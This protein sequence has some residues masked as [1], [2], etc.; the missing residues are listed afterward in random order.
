MSAPPAVRRAWPPWWRWSLRGIAAAAALL[1]VVYVGYVLLGTN[2]HTVIPGAV[3]RTAQPS[4]KRLEAL[5]RTYGI[6]TIVNLR[7][8]CDP[9]PW[10]L[11]ECIAA[12]RLNLSQEDIPF[13]ATRLPPVD[14]VLDRSEKPL[15]LHCNRGA[16]RSGMAATMAVLLQTDTPLHDARHQL[17]PRYGHI[18]LARTSNMDR[19]FDL[20]EEWLAH[21]HLT[22]SSEVFRRWATKEYCPGECR[23]Q[24]EV[25]DHP[26]TPLRLYPAQVF[27]FHIRSR[28][29]SVKPW[30]LR[31]GSNA[32]IHV[33]YTVHDTDGGIVRDGRGALL[34]ATVAPGEEL[35]V[36]LS[37]VAPLTPGRYELRVD[38]VDEQHAYFMQVGSEPL[39]WKLEVV[40]P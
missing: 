12:N 39:C 10:Y 19:F 23:C 11:D 29:T 31:P 36:V 33:A 35:D 16:D 2:F 38:M 15:L 25:L 26:P 4:A 27:P 14:T 6:R 17:G 18:P 13:S 24:F 20:Y 5:V 1:T 9:Y 30:R 8:C 37:I 40:L 22:H 32:G 7:G 21:E 3:Y 34:D 28:N